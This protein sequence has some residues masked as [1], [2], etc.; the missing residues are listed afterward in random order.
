DSSL[1]APG[2]GTPA[3]LAGERFKLTFSLDITHVP[4]NG[5][6]PA[7]AATVGG[8]VPIGLPALPNGLAYVRGGQVRALAVFSSTRTSALPDAPTML[9]ATG[10]DLPA[11]II[12]GFV[13]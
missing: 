4:F 1:C 2:R 10:H 12:N 13:A 5:G 8:H 9:E 3:R 6:G 11:D 7:T